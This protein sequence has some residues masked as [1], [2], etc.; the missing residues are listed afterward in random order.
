MT[1]FAEC[2]PV[3]LRFEGGATITEDPR[4]PGGLTKYGISQRAF[5]TL[6]IRNLT[7]AGAA[8]IYRREYWD[9]LKADTLPPKLRL[10]MF[11]AAVN[12]GVGKAV[13]LLQK[14]VG[15]AQ[16]GILGANTIRAAERLPDALARFCAERALAY[17]GM[18]G[19]DVFG[20][21]WLRRSF[22]AALESN[23]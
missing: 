15:V 9:R 19:F 13:L 11:D 1:T 7:E 14:A 3:I 10:V 23:K 4:D 21:G 2:L 12:M 17:S 5:P 8:D 16:D 18:R 20:R 22:I 6:D